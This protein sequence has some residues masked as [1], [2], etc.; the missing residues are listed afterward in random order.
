MLKTG[1]ARPDLA[2]GRHVSQPTWE[3]LYIGDYKR[4]RIRKGLRRIITAVVAVG[5]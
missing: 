4:F 3:S 5:S 2:G 1:K